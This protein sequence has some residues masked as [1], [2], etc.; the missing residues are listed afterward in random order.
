[1][2]F[3]VA[4]PCILRKIIL[5]DSNITSGPIFGAGQFLGVGNNFTVNVRK[6]KGT[7]IMNEFEEDNSSP[8]FLMIRIQ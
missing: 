3:V 2:I 1:M 8:L 4:L 6:L 7:N 5:S